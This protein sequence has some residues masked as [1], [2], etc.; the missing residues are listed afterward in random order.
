MQEVVSRLNIKLKNT[1]NELADYSET[2]SEIQQTTNSYDLNLFFPFSICQDFFKIFL[3]MMKIK[4]CK[5]SIQH[6][7]KLQVNQNIQKMPVKL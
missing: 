3:E 2:R 4:F 5:T 7:I 1:V 6:Y